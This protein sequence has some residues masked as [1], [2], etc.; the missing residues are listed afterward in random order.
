MRPH[1][2]TE[3]NI[4][5]IAASLPT[6]RPLFQRFL[7]RS[8]RY[9]SNKTRSY[10]HNKGN[11]NGHSLHIFPRTG[12]PL[13]L[14]PKRHTGGCSANG[15]SPK[16]WNGRHP[17]LENNIGDESILPMPIQSS[18]SSGGGGILKTTAVVIEESVAALDNRN[19][20]FEDQGWLGV[21]ETEITPERK[22]EDRF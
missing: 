20:H 7:E 1:R 8:F 21:K 13:A 15:V 3:L 16:S 10:S 19:S 5:I 17:D 12:D 18:T 22:I 9:G 11:G 2:R 6:L 4:G 14:G